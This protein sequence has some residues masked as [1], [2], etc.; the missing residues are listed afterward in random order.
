MPSPDKKPT[1][2]LGE[3]LRQARR[4]KDWTQDRL[5]QELDLPLSQSTISLL[6]AGD[7][8]AASRSTIMRLIEGLGLEIDARIEAELDQRRKGAVLKYCE[9]WRCLSNALFQ[10]EDGTV[11]AKAAMVSAQVNEATRCDFCGR[12]LIAQCPDCGEGLSETVCCRAC[13]YCLVP[14][15][16]KEALGPDIGR[17]IARRREEIAALLRNIEEVHQLRG[18]GNGRSG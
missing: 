18:I 5:I 17:I 2:V 9:S 14:V 11:F 7:L 12:P 15:P 10:T 8:G 6:E 1:N 3:R 4:A 13:G 16:S